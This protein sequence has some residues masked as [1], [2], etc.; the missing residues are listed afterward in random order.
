MELIPNL[1]YEEYA[2]RPGINASLLKVVDGESM[3]HAKA[4]LDG[5]REKESDALDF[6]KCF[7]SLLLE[8]RVD[9]VVQPDTYPAPGKKKND[10][11]VIKPWNNNANFCSDWVKAQGDKIVL[12]KVEAENLEAM[13]AKVRDHR[14]LKPFLNGRCELSIFGQRDGLPIKCRT[15]L[16]PDKHVVIDFKKARSANPKK[17]IKQALEKGYDIQAAWTLDVLRSVGDVREEFWFVAIE[18]D[19]PHAIFIAKFADESLSFL[20]AG[21]IKARAAF[22]RLKNAYAHDDWPDYGSAP[23]EHHASP[24]M[25]KELEQTAG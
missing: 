24:W 13:V 16:L 23:A 2:R 3:A 8:G 9:Y 21:R 1:P 19:F 7:H 12:T 5:K 6:G 17:F 20:R 25:L 11:D 4:T 14:D 10:P 18:E 15:D 22:Q